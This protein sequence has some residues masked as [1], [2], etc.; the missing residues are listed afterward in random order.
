MGAA[1]RGEERGGLDL[2]TV[3]VVDCLQR[4][5]DCSLIPARNLILPPRWELG[6]GA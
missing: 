3:T 1:E 2:L 6:R 4:N 5:K